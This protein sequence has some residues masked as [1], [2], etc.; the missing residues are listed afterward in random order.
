MDGREQLLRHGDISH[1][2]DD[3]SRV[4]DALGAEFDHLPP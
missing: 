4:T 1:L 3:A 2:Q